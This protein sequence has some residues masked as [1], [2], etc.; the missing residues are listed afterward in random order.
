[1]VTAGARRRLVGKTKAGWILAVA[2]GLFAL[3]PDPRV[4]RADVITLRG[5]GQVQGKVVPDPQDKDKV[6]VW[7]L[8]GRKPLSLPKTRIVEVI[9]K[10]SPL[11]EYFVKLKKTAETAQAQYD[12]GTW[13]EQNKLTDL[14]RLHYEAA[15]AIDK[16]FEPAHRKL[17]HIYHD[18]YWLTRDE[19][20]ARQGLVKYKGRWVSAEEKAKRDLEDKALAEQAAWVRRI[21]IL[22]QAIVNG[23]TDR[24][25]EAEAQL[26]AIREAEAVLPLMRVLGNDEPAQ[27]ILLAQVLSAIPAREATVALVKQVLA[28]PLSSVRTVV[29]DKLKDRDDPSVVPRLVKALA[30]SDIMVINRAAWALGNLGA[31]QA[32]PKLITVLVTTEDQIVMVQP[33]NG[34]TGAV[35]GTGGAPLHVN[36]SNIALLTPPAVSQGAVAYG[37]MSAPIYALPPGGGLDVGAQIRQPEPRVA[38]F[39]YRN[40][41]VLAALQKMTNQDF[42]YD[43]QSWRNWVSRQYNPNPRPARRVP[44][45]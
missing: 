26:M 1:M 4:A 22:R 15:L 25:R 45:P 17:G 42:G 12:F 31:V 20:S 6:Q 34:N 27:R 7:L 16:S 36:N 44:Q 33:G 38:T 3:G 37:A 19:L 5:G 2:C 28:E 43:M 32:V 30:S 13:C 11:D 14:A 8:Q 41:E 9:P 23:P 40:V 35:G 29:Y 24:R 21:K 39:T 10:V 18:G